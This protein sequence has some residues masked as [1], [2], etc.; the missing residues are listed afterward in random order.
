[1]TNQDETVDDLVLAD[2]QKPLIII[3]SNRGP[4]AFEWHKKRK[5]LTV[6]RG[7]GGL[8]TALGALAERH[9][10]LWVAAALSKGDRQWVE[11]NE[12]RPQT[13]EGVLLRLVRP[14]RRA[15]DQYYNVVANPLLWFIQHQLWDIPRTPSITRETWRAWEKGY[16]A[17]NRLFAEAIADSIPPTDRPVI[18]FPQDYHLYLVPRYLR[19]LLGARVQIQPFI[20]IPWPGPDAWRILP[21]E[22]RLSILTSLLESDRVGFQTERDAFNFVQCCRIYVPDAHSRGARDAIYYKERK[23][24]ARAY[25]ISVD[26]DKLESLAEEPQ[27]PL[28]KSQ[29]INFTGDRK[30][31]LRVD[32]IEP[33]KNILR[34]LEAYRALLEN[35]PQHRGKVQML[36]LLV[37]SRMEV[38]EYQDYLQQIMAQAG[39]INAEYSDPYWEPVRIMVGENYYRAIA[40]FQLYDVLLVTPIADGMNLVAKEGVLVNQRDGVLL[41]S[42]SAGVFYELGDHALVVSPFDIYGTAETMHRALEM[43]PDERRRRAEAMRRHVRGAGVKTW[44]YDQVDDAMQAF[45]SQDRNAST[46]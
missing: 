25:P 10:V 35:H 27:T 24:E 8:V 45:N 16:V 5:E 41:L 21:Q 38:G 7:S 3:A 31:I 40:A 44:F 37:P 2:G 20:H 4:Y 42:E 15:Y 17:V 22:M 14:S 11:M 36:A 19:E 33:S 46:S 6:T 23:V 29:L 28:L 26:V 12:D 39:M 43:T 34:S 18:V 13:V 32:R 1:M 30:L 9:E